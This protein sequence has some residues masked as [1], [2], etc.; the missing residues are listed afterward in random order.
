M[1]KETVKED[2]KEVATNLERYEAETKQQEEQAKM[3]TCELFGTGDQF[4]ET[5]YSDVDERL[6]R[7]YRNAIGKRIRVA[8]KEG[9]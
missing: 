7:N 3:E 6:E 5:S 1:L 4:S 8:R 2:H 9:A